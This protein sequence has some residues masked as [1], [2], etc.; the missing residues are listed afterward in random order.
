MNL[1]FILNGVTLKIS[2]K[3]KDRAIC[4]TLMTIIRTKIE[5]FTQVHV[6]TEQSCFK[7]KM[8]VQMQY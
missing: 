5:I 2:N 3:N 6:V 4:R 8:V 7:I 1:I